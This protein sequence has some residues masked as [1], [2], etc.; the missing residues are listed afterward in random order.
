M[1][2]S[3]SA[4]FLIAGFGLTW[5]ALLL[6]AWRL[7]ARLESARVRLERRGDGGPRAGFAGSGEAAT[8]AR[9]TEEES[10]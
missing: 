2:T 7:E 8:E 6:Y 9:T 10:G 3:G 4:P 1:P 5:G